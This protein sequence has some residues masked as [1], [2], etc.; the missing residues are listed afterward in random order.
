MNSETDVL[1]E[2]NTDL[3]DIVLNHR[4][5]ISWQAENMDLHVPDNSKE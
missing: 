4:V 2:W 5:D 1:Y 3:L